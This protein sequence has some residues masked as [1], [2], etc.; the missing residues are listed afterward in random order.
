MNELLQ[1]IKAALKQI[2]PFKK[3]VVGLS[4]GMDSVVLTHAL[5]HLG[6]E[7]IVAHLNHGLRG[8]ASEADE[9]FVVALAKKWELPYLVKKA[10][11]PIQGNQENQARIIRYAYLEEVRQAYHADFIAVGHHFDDQIETVL[12]HE[13]RG[14]GLRGRR[15]MQL[16]SGKIIRPMLDI[17]QREVE[18]Y[19]TD[20]R[21][22]FC[23]DESNFNVNFERSH[24]RHKVIPKLRE[25]PGFEQ[26]I[27]HKM[28][29]VNKKLQN[30]QQEKN[31]W[32]E[33]NF[34][35]DRFDRHAFNRLEQDL[36]V[37]IL[38]HLL[39][40]QDLY[41]KTLGRLINF[42]QAGKTGKE[43]SV[44]TRCFRIEY[45]KIRCVSQALAELEPALIHSE[46]NWGDYHITVKQIKNLK[47]RTWKEVDRFRPAGMKGTK[48]LQNFFV[49]EKIPRHE[50]K[51]IPIL[52]NEKDEIV[53]V[54]N[55][56]FSDSFIKLKESVQ[57]SKKPLN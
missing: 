9:A 50:R 29:E 33:E 46:V 15:G 24:F 11:I 27:R 28:A 35:D 12:M 56:R 5:K 54:G 42:I 2:P 23:T 53:C 21:L 51:R 30:L 37:E 47:V 20:Q 18:A 19:S 32:L 55:L 25:R 45:D 36:K 48:K 38:I 31:E 34:K 41:S 43:L 1:P 49:D 52:V 39:G 22:D 10:V 7:V 14:A 6:Y 26:E 40:S 16:I 44:K 3:V 8:K 4:G 13:K 17:P 57:V